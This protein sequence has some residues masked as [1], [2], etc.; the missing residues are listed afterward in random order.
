MMNNS[1][2]Q[3]NKGINKS[4]EFQGLRAQYI[5]YFGGMVLL[6]LVLFAVLYIAGAGTIICLAVVGGSGVF[7]SIKI[8]SLSHR[9]GEY[10]LMKAIAK[11]RVPK[12]LKSYSR[13]SFQ[14]LSSTEG[15]I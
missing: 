3:I 9:Y 14:H 7:I 13:R 5:W 10:G 6:L 4:I 11:K 8:F 15:G 12:V 1:I 2:Y